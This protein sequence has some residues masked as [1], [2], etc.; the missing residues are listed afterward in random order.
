MAVL[1]R[2]L[3]RTEI[4]TGVSIGLEYLWKITE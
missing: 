2:L 1:A 3:G 4:R